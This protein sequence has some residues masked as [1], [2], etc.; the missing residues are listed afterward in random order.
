[1]ITKQNL[2]INK[3]YS[4]FILLQIS[5]RIDRL[6]KIINFLEPRRISWVISR[7]KVFKPLFPRLIESLLWTHKFG[8]DR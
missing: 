1:M 8:I 6:Y 4:Y 5:R 3:K 2:S 7:E